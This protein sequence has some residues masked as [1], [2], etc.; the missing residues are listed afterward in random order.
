MIIRLAQAADIPGMLGL[1]TQ[2]CNVHQAIR[3]DIFKP[4]G[5]KYDESALGE[6]IKDP[7]K[8][9][10][11]AV[12]DDF[13]KGYCFCVLKDYAGSTVRT[14]HRELY[15]DDLCVDETCRGQGVA[16]AL[17]DHVKAYAKDIGCA[18]IT[19]NVWCGNDNAMAFYEN[20]GLT[21]RHIMM[22]TRL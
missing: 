18:Y 15:I 1:L 2:V 12:E 17:Y 21:P 6:L 3:P 19:L 8:P 10:F 4:D 7:Q 5:V 16:T 9:I 22:E 14:D 20:R 11:V 13:L